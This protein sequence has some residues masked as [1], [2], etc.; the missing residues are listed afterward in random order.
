MATR[1]RRPLL[2]LGTTILIMQAVFMPVGMVYAGTTMDTEEQDLVKLPPVKNYLEE[3]SASDPHFFSTRSQVQGRVAESIQVTFYSDQEVSET[4]V[5]LPEEAMI[6]KE[7]LPTGISIEQGEQPLEWIIQSKRAQHTFVLPLTFKEEGDYEVS[8][9]EATTQ[10]N[11]YTQEEHVTSKLPKEDSNEQDDSFIEK[12]IGSSSELPSKITEKADEELVG[13]IESKDPDKE[14]PG[15]KYTKN[16][17]DLRAFKERP[18]QPEISFFIDTFHANVNQLIFLQIVNQTDKRSYTVRIPKESAIDQASLSQGITISNSHGEYW[19]VETEEVEEL[20]E[21]PIQFSSKGSFFVSVDD[22]ASHMFLV[23]EEI[24]NSRRNDQDPIKAIDEQNLSL[25]KK[26]IEEEE[27]RI[28]EEIRDSHNRSNTYARNWSQFRSAWNNSSVTGIYLEDTIP[29][30]SSILGDSLNSRFTSVSVN[31]YLRTRAQINMRNSG[32][33]LFMSGS[34]NLALRVP[35]ISET[36]NHSLPL[37]EHSGSGEILL[38]ESGAVINRSRAH[39]VRMSGSSTLRLESRRSVIYNEQN[40]SPVRLSFYSTLR[41]TAG[42]I[43]GNVAGNNN[44]PPIDSTA[45]SSIYIIGN[46]VMMGGRVE[47]IEHLSNTTTLNGVE[48]SLRQLTTYSIGWNSVDVHLTGINGSV[49]RSAVSR[50]NDFSTRYLANVNSTQYRSLIVNSSDSVGG[51]VSHSLT[52]EASPVTGGN[53]TTADST[54]PPGGTT[55]IRANPSN[56]YRF[57][58]WEV[59]GSGSS[60][61]DATNENTTFTMGSANATVRAE[62]ERNTYKLELTASPV[63][64]GNPTAG[65]KTLAQGAKTEL[66]ANPNTGYRFSHWELRSGAGASIEDFDKLTTIFTMGSGNASVHAHYERVQTLNLEASPTEGGELRAD[67]HSLVQGETTTITATPNSGYRFS[68]WEIRSG[69]GSSIANTSAPST[70]FTMGNSNAT[71]RAVFEIDL[72]SPLD[73]LDPEREVDPENKPELPEDQGMLTIDFVSSFQFGEQS[74]SSK[75]Q[76][77]FARPQ[78]LL[79]DDGTVNETEERPNYIQIS[80]RRSVQ[81]RDGW[82]LSVRQKEQFKTSEGQELTGA[83]LVFQNQQVTTA[84]DGIEPGLIRRNQMTLNPDGSKQTLMKAQDTEGTGTWI[85]RFGDAETARE[86][87]RL[88]VPR[89]ANPSADSYKTTLSWELSSVPP[90]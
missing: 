71:V 22:D 47:P 64:G 88:Y 33:S 49:I 5:V 45:D 48:Y 26:L 62:Y 3:E 57:V 39:A 12:E 63:E 84:Q 20:V 24:N 73:P 11:I 75:N 46:N 80:D 78:R 13:E 18:D 38:A 67:L 68:H 72:I 23:V 42:S 30:S 21:L 76:F 58:R 25:P 89:G 15:K 1:F 74:I 60:I 56:G 29:F 19:M 43:G 6:L 40:F 34:S 55:T 17:L 54:I 59:T 81:D 37:V 10:L 79:N 90:N 44:I 70:T 41:M 50:P 9:G 35:I 16:Q 14:T 28:L 86:S 7:Q 27:H 8:I 87:V 65:D 4:R 51:I 2:V 77:Y 61:A 36:A 32:N 83:Q 52:M 85:Y 66:T 53:P 31:P 69:S 82:E